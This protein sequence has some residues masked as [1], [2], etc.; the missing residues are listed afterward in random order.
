[1]TKSLDQRLGDVRADLVAIETGLGRLAVPLPPEVQFQFE[2]VTVSA[3]SIDHW[4]S[5]LDARQVARQALN[6][7]GRDVDA[8][9]KVPYGDTRVKF[10]HARLLGVQA[11]LSANWSLADSIAAMAGR[12]FCVP[13]IGN[14]K[15]S[16]AH[17]NS[18]FVGGSRKKDV[19]TSI[20]ESV[21]RIFGWPVAIS[22]ALRNHFQ[23][24]GGAQISGSN[25]FQG[26]NAASAFR[27]SDPGWTYIEDKATREYQV[28]PASHRIPAGWLATPKDDL[29]IVLDV[30]ERQVD[31]ALGILAGSA[32][33]TL[34]GHLAFL[35]GED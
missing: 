12:V 24:D 22:Y 11:Y 4:I 26:I 8:D 23:H 1:M 10:Q 19:A 5:L 20:F 15:L 2:A 6:N 34:R 18:T 29:R 17:L 31:D 13:S 28:A 3:G 16:P 27:I 9:D 21:H 30:C 7:L 25:F 33:K 35:I 14:N 32:T